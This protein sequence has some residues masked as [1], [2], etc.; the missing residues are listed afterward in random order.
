MKFNLNFPHFGILKFSKS[1]HF[2][3]YK[4]D[5]CSNYPISVRLVGVGGL[6]EMENMDFEK[7]N[8]I[9]NMI[10]YLFC[11]SCGPFEMGL[12]LHCKVIE[13]IF[14]IESDLFWKN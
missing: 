9:K 1:L 6:R 3:V 12:F 4:S 10:L 14:K 7:V 2:T 5:S 11:F 8:C 13:L